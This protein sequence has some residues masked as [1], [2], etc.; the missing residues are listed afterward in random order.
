[1]S[2]PGTGALLERDESLARLTGLAQEVAGGAGRLVL[3]GGEAGV[4]KT[5][6]LRRFADGLQCRTLW[7]ACDALRTPR[8]LGPL[9]D[10]AESAHGE[11]AALLAGPA[12]P[13]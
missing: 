4:G 9:L 5:A 12:P 10:V 8:P 13:H 1:M 11:L 3:V 6:L 2:V 7:G